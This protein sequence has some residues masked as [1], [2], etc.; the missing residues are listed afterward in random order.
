MCHRATF[1]SVKLNCLY[2]PLNSDSEHER[3]LPILYLFHYLPPS[4]HRLFAYA[5]NIHGCLATYTCRY[6]SLNLLKWA[7]ALLW[8]KRYQR[9]VSI[10]GKETC[11][12]KKFCT[13]RYFSPFHL[14]KLFLYWRNYLYVKQYR[15]FIIQ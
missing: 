3:M 13:K 4:L 6:K 7:C 2:L 9:Q 5:L 12:W 11:R 14:N 10:K 8:R 15:L 1:L